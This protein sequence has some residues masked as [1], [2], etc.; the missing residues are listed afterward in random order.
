[1]RLNT[2]G[3]SINTS[4]YISGTTIIN[5]THTCTS[6]LNVSGTTTLQGFVGVGNNGPFNSYGVF[7][8]GG[9]NN[10]TYYSFLNKSRIVGNDPNTIWQTSVSQPSICL[11]T[12]NAYIYIQYIYIYIYIYI[13]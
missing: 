6:S 12:S 11:T 8:V 9:N 3:T 2:A 10:T 4:L 1:M 13:S 5:S 7:D